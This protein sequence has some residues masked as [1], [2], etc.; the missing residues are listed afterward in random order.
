MSVKMFD[1]GTLDVVGHRKA[2]FQFFSIFVFFKFKTTV[3]KFWKHHWLIFKADKYIG[4]LFDHV[5]VQIS[6]WLSV[7]LYGFKTKSRDLPSN[8]WF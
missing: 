6:F 2:I 3:I 1:A 7:L 4:F 8:V 5:I